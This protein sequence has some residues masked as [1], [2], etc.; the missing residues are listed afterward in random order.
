MSKNAAYTHLPMTLTS[1]MHQMVYSQDA[2]YPLY[3][4]LIKHGVPSALVN[5]IMP[6]LDTARIKMRH[7]GIPVYSRASGEEGFVIGLADRPFKAPH[8]CFQHDAQYATVEDP[9]NPGTMIDV[10]CCRFCGT[11]MPLLAESDS[12]VSAK[13]N[14]T[15][16]T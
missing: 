13:E 15:K 10:A 7:S 6:A 14:S 3:E 11:K 5:A 12:L 4:E 9:E 8:Q 16:N 2:G 1:L